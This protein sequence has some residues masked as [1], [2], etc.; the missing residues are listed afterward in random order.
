MNTLK[1]NQQ[2]FT[3][4][5]VMIFIAVSGVIFMFGI[6]NMLNTQSRDQFTVS[7][8]T[9]KNELQSYLNNSSNGNYQLP[10]S[11]QCVNGGSRLQIIPKAGNLP[12]NSSSCSYLGS[13]LLF[14]KNTSQLDQID[15]LPIFGYTFGNG[16]S[17]QQN[18]PNS[19]SLAQSLPI[20]DSNLIHTYFIP[21][22]IKIES[23]SYIDTNNR[24]INQQT[25]LF[26][27]LNN[28]NQ[29]STSSLLNS[30]SQFSEIVPIKSPNI[31]NPSDAVRYIN[32]LTDNCGQPASQIPV[33]ACRTY[34]DGSLIFGSD[35]PINPSSGISICLNNTNNSESADL[36]IGNSSLSSTSAIYTKLYN[37]VGC[38]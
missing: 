18:Q 19:T 31:T 16:G 11:Y 14:L 6:S 13:G 26:L 27:L 2:G 7:L 37:T 34:S 17:F 21:G 23:I 38:I 5:E 33:I 3:I 30:G 9:V 8:N 35:A 12:N 32:Q 10:S 29:Y 28:F 20:T 4:I 24:N 25:N 15:I 36:I 1:N 22:S